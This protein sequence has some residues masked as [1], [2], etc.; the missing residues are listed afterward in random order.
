VPK[1]VRDLVALAPGRKRL[2]TWLEARA[3]HDDVYDTYFYDTFVDPT[4]AMSADVMAASI[5]RD[6]RPS[7]VLDVGCGSGGLMLALAQRGVS[8]SGLEYSEAGIAK[9]RERGLK[10]SRFDIEHDLAETG[11]RADLAIST[12][13]A[14]HLPETAA[15]R[16]VSLLCSLSDTIVM[17]A[18]TPG[19][20]GTDH[21][22]EQPHEYWI[23]K[24]QQRGFNLDRSATARWREGWSAAN[25]AGCFAQNVMLFRRTAR[26]LEVKR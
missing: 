12:E 17:T 8:V 13:V 7:T 21:I 26:P 4:M 11:W 5:V 16:F 14:E 20:G 15:D 23:Q 22:N 18:A 1:R 24:L 6:L 9:C 3:E 25:V 10:V 19:Q 2:I